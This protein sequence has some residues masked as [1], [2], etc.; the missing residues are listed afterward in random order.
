MAITMN[1]SGQIET[2]LSPNRTSFTSVP[3]YSFCSSVITTTANYT[4]NQIEF[5]A[6][7]QEI[8]IVNFG[9]NPVA[10]QFSEFFGTT[11]DSGLVLANSSVVIRTS[12]KSGIALKNADVGA[13]SVVVF[14]V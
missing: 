2:N 11:K 12:L 3:T 13:S 14:A 6:K 1:G 9:A 4:A 5:G 8:H 7:I 10:F